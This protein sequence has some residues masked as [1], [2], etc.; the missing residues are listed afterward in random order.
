MAKHSAEDLVRQ[1]LEQTVKGKLELRRTNDRPPEFVAALPRRY[2]LL[3][4][5]GP[6][7][8]Q[9]QLEEIADGS[10]ASPRF[11]L[12]DEADAEVLRVTGNA[13]PLVSELYDAILQTAASAAIGD[14]VAQLAKL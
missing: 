1:A 6:G 11:L 4:G 8:M 5:G 10:S 9:A 3:V 13:C 12:R 2:T 7:I 14:A